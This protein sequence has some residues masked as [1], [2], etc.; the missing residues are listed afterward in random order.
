MRSS[1]LYGSLNASY[2]TSQH[3]GGLDQRNYVLI[4]NVIVRRS[5]FAGDRYSSHQAMADLGYLKFVDS[6]WV[7]S[8]DRLQI[9]LLWSTS[10]ARW[11]RSYLVTF[12]TQFLPGSYTA[13]DEALGRPTAR[14]VGGFLVPFDLGISHGTVFTFWGASTVD[15]AWATVRF[16]SMPKEFTPAAFVDANTLQGT[17]VYY[18]LSYGFGLAS[19]INKRIGDRVQW[20]NNSHFF[21]NGID[22]DHV[23]M[24]LTNLV[25]VKL[26]KYVQL[27]LDTRL[28][29]NPLFSYDLQF[30]QEVLLGFF[31]ER[32]K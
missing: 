6:T 24:D 25:I 4:G 12:G 10:R 2:A 15:I 32:N 19:A 7:K 21:G 17:R 8:L 20:I 18:F 14:S 26:W 11:S 31:Y 27:R 9:N 13:F 23:N 3:W 1:S 29:Y 5:V 16:N 28:L 30:R 22:R